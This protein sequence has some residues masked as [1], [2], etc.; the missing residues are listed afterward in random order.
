MTIEQ[1]YQENY[2]I[3]YGFLLS[4][5]RDPALA[6]D[7]ASETFLRAI[8]KIKSYDG[9][10]KP[11]TWLCTIAKN[12]YLNEKKRQRRFVHLDDTEI[13]DAHC[14]EEQVITNEQLRLILVTADQLQDTYRQVFFMRINGLCF[15]EIGEA[16]G[17]TENWARV[18]YFRAKNM[19]LQQL[20]EWR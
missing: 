13:P 2:P 8:Q 15:R 18:T 5:C 11:S 20:E 12:L 4:L 19:I 1:I 10:C 3:V 9:V 16:L 17:K 6:E 7:L 14:F